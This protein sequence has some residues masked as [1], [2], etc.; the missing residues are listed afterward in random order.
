MTIMHSFLIKGL[1]PGLDA[2]DELVKKYHT[3]G[4]R[5][6]LLAYS[7]G[8][9]WMDYEPDPFIYSYSFAEV[10]TAIP[11][12]IM[13]VFRPGQGV[14]EHRGEIAIRRNR[15]ERMYDNDGVTEVLFRD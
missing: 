9:Y 13:S 5:F 11:D 10:Y 3:E 15:N 12:L 4:V 2:L 1:A 8:C 7:C 6:Y 14:I